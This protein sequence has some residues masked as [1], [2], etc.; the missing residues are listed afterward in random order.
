MKDSKPSCFYHNCIK[1][2]LPGRG[3]RTVVLINSTKFL[4]IH[5][6][7]TAVKV[8]SKLCHAIREAIMAGLEEVHK[9]FH[10]DL[11]EAEIGF[12]CSGVCGNTDDP[13]IATLDDE[14]KTWTC[15]EDEGRGSDLTEREHVW[16]EDPKKT[17]TS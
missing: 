6:K 14:K 7:S 17:S 12:L 16:L 5:V 9:S 4:E 3:P 15:C 8:D 11:P 1:F 2:T 10:Y 13:H